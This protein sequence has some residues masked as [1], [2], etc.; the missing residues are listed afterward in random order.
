MIHL[1]FLHTDISI[2][3]TCREV[4]SAPFKWRAGLRVGDH[5]DQVQTID[6]VMLTE[7]VLDNE[8]WLI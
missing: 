7:E 1:S 3:V 6:E 8:P 5:N 2:G 4:L